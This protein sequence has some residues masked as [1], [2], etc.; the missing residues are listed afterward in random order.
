MKKKI[1]EKKA[2]KEKLLLDQES[3]KS[4]RTKTFG[5]VISIIL[6][7]VFGAFVV[8]CYTKSRTDENVTWSFLLL[9]F[10]ALALGGLGLSVA[11]GEKATRI[12]RFARREALIT[13]TYNVENYIKLNLYTKRIEDTLYT[14]IQDKLLVYAKGKKTT[15]IHFENVTQFSYTEQSLLIWVKELF[16]PIEIRYCAMYEGQFPIVD[17]NLVNSINN[18]LAS[19]IVSNAMGGI[20]QEPKPPKYITCQFC[21]AR[22]IE[23]NILCTQCG[24]RLE[25]V[26]NENK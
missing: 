19:Y 9:I 25:E 7:V 15:V 14:S 8:F 11:L 5:T 21:G 1:K 18:L 23:S 26:K 22:N 13:K 4:I 2:K 3:K 12:Y 20:K 16:E 6:T 17:V 24:A 10:L